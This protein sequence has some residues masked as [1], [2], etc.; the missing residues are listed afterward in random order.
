M[1]SLDVISINIWQI[2][3]SLCNLLILYLILR[4]L[5]FKPVKNLIAEREAMANAEYDKANAARAAAEKSRGEWD[6][7]MKSADE[8]ASRI[9]NTASEN[10]KILS[11]RI[12]AEAKDRAEHIVASAK[13]EADLEYKRAS[14]SI[15]GEIVD[16][17][18]S[19]VEKVLE[20]EIDKEKHHAI[21]NSFLDKIGA[22]AH[23]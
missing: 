14:D 5:L 4:K 20:S 19:I 11:E 10:A 8:E 17:S 15:R 23:E 9:V 16:V 21:I 22:D 18:T 2:A 1:Q 13:T 3:I 7:K 12:E 6:E